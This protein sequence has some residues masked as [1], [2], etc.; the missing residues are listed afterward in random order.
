MLLH[1]GLHVQNYANSKCIIY[2]WMSPSIPILLSEDTPLKTGP[3]T[4]EQLSWVGSINSIGALFGT[5]ITGLLITFIGCK[6]ATL[7]LSVPTIL[8]WVLIYIGDT[9]N[10]IL[11]ARIFTGYTGGSIQTTLILFTS[12]IANDK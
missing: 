12:E 3:L 9:Y 2:R 1:I 6:R 11:I 10:H 5:F 4:N 8:F 7:L